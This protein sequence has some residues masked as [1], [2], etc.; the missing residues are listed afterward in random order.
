MVWSQQCLVF[1]LDQSSS[2]LNTSEHGANP[3]LLWSNNLS[4]NISSFIANYLSC[5]DGRMFWKWFLVPLPKLTSCLMHTTFW[6]SLTPSKITSND[7]STWFS[8]KCFH[9]SAENA[10][11]AIMKIYGIWWNLSLL[12]EARCRK[13]I[14]VWNPLS[15]SKKTEADPTTRWCANPVLKRNK[16][17]VSL[18]IFRKSIVNTSL[19]ESLPKHAKTSC[20]LPQILA[21][22]EDFRSRGVHP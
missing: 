1:F 18:R 11:G 6:G 3:L 7:T 12:S 21:E 17:I 16:E 13:K 8:T 4:E 22:K 5:C 2:C 9:S 14:M 20:V 10:H 19:D 15:K